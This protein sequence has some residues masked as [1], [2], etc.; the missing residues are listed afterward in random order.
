M[1][2]FPEDWSPYSEI[3]LDARVI[4]AA[5]DSLRFGV[6][7][8][9][10]EGRRDD[11]WAQQSFYATRQWQTFHLPVANRKVLHGDR[12]LDLS[13]IEALLVYVGVPK[14]SFALEIDNIRLQ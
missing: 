9:D 5:G 4:R 7:V 2:N 11:V 6:R 13:D 10:F 8:D 14:D 3:V 1:T 12:I